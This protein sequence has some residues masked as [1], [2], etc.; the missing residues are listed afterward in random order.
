MPQ[1]NQRDIRVFRG[2]AFRQCQNILTNALECI[3]W[4]H[5]TQLAVDFT[6]ATVSAMILCI[7]AV[8]V[9]IERI[10]QRFVATTVLRTTVHD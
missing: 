4:P 8:A 10:C 3:G 9:L 6:R 7:H 2:S 1:D 5:V